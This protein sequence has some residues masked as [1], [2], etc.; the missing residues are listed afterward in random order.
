MTTLTSYTATTYTSAD[1]VDTDNAALAEHMSHC[2]NKRSRFFGLHAA[3][4]AVQP[5]VFSRMVTAALL[6]V[7]ILAVVG[8]V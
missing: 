1:F 4:E 7:V 8:I 5:V 2:A 3:L 6:A